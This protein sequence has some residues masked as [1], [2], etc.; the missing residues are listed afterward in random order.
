MR[1]AVHSAGYMT[2]LAAR[3]FAR[4]IDGHLKPL[5]LSSAYLPVLFALKNEDALTQKVLAQTAAVEQP[6]MA[7]TLI[8]MERDGLIFRRPD[9]QDKRSAL[10]SLTPLARQKGPQVF[11]L[12]EAVNGQAL[13]GLTPEEAGQYLALLAKVVASFD[14]DGTSAERMKAPLDQT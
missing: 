3:L 5:G 12:V 14:P 1:R 8:R 13:S 7:A 2:N 9:P 11:A 10:I 6:T 4:T